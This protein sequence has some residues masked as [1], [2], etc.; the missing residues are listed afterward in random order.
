MLTAESLEGL[1]MLAGVDL[2]LRRELLESARIVSVGAGELL[3]AQGDRLDCMYL[4]LEGELGVYLQGVDEEPIA[5]IAAG[6]TVGEISV[7]DRTEASASVRCHADCRLVAVPEELFW[8]LV[9][10]SHAFT[11][12]LLLTL[13]AR[14]R[15]SNSVLSSSLH[16][17]RLYERAALFDALT[18]IHNRRWLED[19]LQRMVRRHEKTAGHLSVAMLDIDHFKN[20]NDSLGHLAGDIVLRHVASVLASNIRPTDLIARFGGEEFVLIFPDTE[21]IHAARAADRVRESVT[22]RPAPSPDGGLLPVVTVSIGIAQLEAGQTA[23]ALLA[24]ADRAL[25]EAKR[26]G[27]DRVVVAEPSRART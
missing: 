10:R 16:S 26:A 23:D 5:V 3:L 1:P 11:V 25:Y 13:A 6:E 22:S 17:R 9:Q 2:S 27:R 19:A 12:N 24:V 7:L 8:S 14:H 20:V 4:V 18:G 21:A 15:N